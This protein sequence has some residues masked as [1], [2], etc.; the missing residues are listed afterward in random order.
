[1]GVGVTR[2]LTSQTAVNAMTTWDPDGPGPQPPQLIVG[3]AI[4]GAGG[5][6]MSGLGSWDGLSWRSMGTVENGSSAP[7]LNALAVYNSEVVVGGN[8]NGAGGVAANSIAR[9][10]GVMWRPLGTGFADPV[11]AEV[12]ALCIYNGEL[13]AGG[14][15][16]TADGNPVSNIARWNGSA[17]HAL[18]AGVSGGNVVAM[19][20]FNGELIAAGGFDTAG[21]MTA[22]RIARWDGSTWGTLGS[23]LMHTTYPATAY[24]VCV[25]GNHLTAGGLFTSAGGVDAQGIASWDGSAWQALGAGVNGIAYAVAEFNGDVI[26]AGD[27]TQ[28][29]GT[30]VNHIARWS[31]AS[32]QPVG[33]GILPSLAWVFCLATFNSELVAGGTFDTAGGFSVNSISRWDGFTWKALGNGLN[34]AALAATT[35]NGDAVVGGSFIQAAGVP[36]AHIARWDG[37]RMYPLGS[38]V[39]GGDVYAMTVRDP[40]LIVGGAFTSADGIATGGVARWDGSWHAMASGLSGVRALTVFNGEVFAG[41]AFEFIGSVFAGRIARWDGA[42]WQPIAYGVG[43]SNGSTPVVNA[44]ATYSNELIVGGSFSSAGAAA[45][46]NIAA[47][48]GNAWHG[49]GSGLPGVI[50]AVAVYNGDLYAAG[51]STLSRWNGTSWESMF[52]FTGTNPTVYALCVANG[53]LVAGGSFTWGTSNGIARWNG[54]SWTYMGAGTGGSFSVSAPGPTVR[55][56]TVHHGEVLALGDF[57]YVLSSPGALIDSMGWAR[58]S[59]GNQ[60]WIATQPQAPATSPSPGGNLALTVTPAAGYASLTY[61]WRKDDV[62][63]S[64]GQSASGSVIAGASTPFLFVSG[65]DGGDSGTYDVRV[66]SACGVLISDPVAVSLCAANCD[67]STI[68]PILNINDFQCFLNEFAAGDLRANCDGS[69]NPPVLNANDFQCFVNLFAAG[70]P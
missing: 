41:G 39:A 54:S 2:Q 50:N 37:A 21:G 64:N 15:F 56:L 6:P 60:P 36:A 3:G 63:L 35:Y 65:L 1:M 7:L 70:C 68:P 40:D 23:G 34:N 13:I 29:G 69:T 24:S 17:W 53:E 55:A 19:C 61:Q 49:L 25:H 32:W 22:N 52:P 27:F 46:S 58:W 8:F 51:A 11:L 14:R 26:A 44:L 45:A 9:W 20:V 30:T 62:P 18:G 59:A 33:A 4:G 47:W 57:T 28:A 48:D 42:A 5:V 67:G 31:G 43:Q 12:N 38:G 16:T 10:D 66:S